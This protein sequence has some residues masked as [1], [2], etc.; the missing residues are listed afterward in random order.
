MVY[1]SLHER[2]RFDLLAPIPQRIA[3]LEV[4]VLSSCLGNAG[5][6]QKL[7]RK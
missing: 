1:S 5:L 3:E 2:Q 7:L 4:R 6:E